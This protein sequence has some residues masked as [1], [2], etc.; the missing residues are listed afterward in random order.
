MHYLSATSKF[1]NAQR[2]NVAKYNA[3][4]LTVKN[5]LCIEIGFCA[6]I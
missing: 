5:E 6:L 2:N 1:N 3:I 4:P